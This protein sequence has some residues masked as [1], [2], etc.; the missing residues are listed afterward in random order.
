MAPPASRE[1]DHL[2]LLEAELQPPAAYRRVATVTNGV[3][4]L[5]GAAGVVVAPPPATRSSRARIL[6]VA[7]ASAGNFFNCRRLSTAR[8]EFFPQARVGVRGRSGAALRF[9]TTHLEVAL[10]PGRPDA[11]RW[12]SSSP[13]PRTRRCR[14]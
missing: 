2:E 7:G 8:G 10:G 4:Q 1:A 14:S 5:A 13:V 11:A 9:V 3:V 12:A 6:E